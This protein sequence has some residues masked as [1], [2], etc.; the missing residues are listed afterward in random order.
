MIV[1]TFEHTLPDGRKAKFTIN[2]KRVL[3]QT[4]YFAQVIALE[5]MTSK[6]DEEKA[7]ELGV[8]ISDEE[9]K[10]VYYKK[11]K[12]L[13]ADL[14]LLYGRTKLKSNIY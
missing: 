2:D 14:I 8:T 7:L 4:L 1:D 5:L 6:T 13:K 12:E 9:G 3:K 10:T 11:A